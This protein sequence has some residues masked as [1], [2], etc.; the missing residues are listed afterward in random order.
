[1]APSAKEICEAYSACRVWLVDATY[2]SNKFL[3]AMLHVVGV[4]STGQTFTFSYCFKQQER[5][6]DCAW[7]MDHIINGFT[8]FEIIGNNN[9]IC[10]RS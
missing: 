2:K 10:D 7:T 3:V 8:D 1:M 9:D 4:T 5:D 6:E